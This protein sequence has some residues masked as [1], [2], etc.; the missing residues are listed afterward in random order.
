M[1]ATLATPTRHWL[2]L[3]LTGLLL[4]PAPASGQTPESSD[5]TLV[6]IVR[7][8]EKAPDPDNDP[9]L[10]G[11]GQRR[12]RVLAGMLA[13]AGI[14]GIYATQYR[15]TRETAA[16]LA[17]ALDLE[18]HVREVS[19]SGIRE[20]AEALAGE[21]LHRHGGESVLVVGHSNTVGPLVEAFTGLSV[22]SPGESDYDN[23]YLVLSRAPGRGRLVQ[24]G[25]PALAGD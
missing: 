13:D 22:E 11:L 23:L 12:A 3:L 10:D 5:Q 16:P 17:E 21:I 7:H 6:V 8:A 24:A 1:T 4:A 18:V 19:R 15:R 20:Y 25:F 9:G 14:S 2:A